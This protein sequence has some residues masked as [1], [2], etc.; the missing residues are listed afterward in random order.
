VT[1]IRRSP[2]AMSRSAEAWWIRPVL[3][4]ALMDHMKDAAWSKRFMARR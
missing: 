4:K 3:P 1:G 2:V